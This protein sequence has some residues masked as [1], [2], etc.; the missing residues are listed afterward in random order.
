MP[1]IINKIQNMNA[2]EGAIDDVEVIGGYKV[3]QT[4]AELQAL[5]ELHVNEGKKILTN[6]CA[7][8]VAATGILYRWD[9]GN[10]QFVAK[11]EED[12]ALVATT[13]NFY[14]LQNIPTLTV[15][16]D[17]VL[18]ATGTVS[19]EGVSEGE[20]D[21]I[22]QQLREEIAAGG[23]SGGTVNLNIEDG[24]GTGAVQQVAD[25]VEGGF[26]F[27]G[28]N[29]NAASFDSSLNGTVPYGAT[30][31]YAAAF[32]GVNSASGSRAFAVNN[33]TIAKGDE[34]FAQGYCSVALGGSSFAGGVKTTAVGEGAVSLG[35][36]TKAVGDYTTAEGSETIAS[37]KH[38]HAEGYQTN[39]TV[40]AEGSHAEGVR[41]TTS[42]VAAHAEGDGTFATGAFSHAEG[43]RARATG[44][45]AHAEG[46]DTLA[47]GNHSHAEGTNCVAEGDHSHAGG[48]NSTAKGW[49]SFA[50][51][52][53]VIATAEGQ[54]VV[55]KFNWSDTNSLFEVG[56]GKDADNRANAFW[57]TNDGRA[58][59]RTAPVDD[60]DV[61]TKGFMT[62]AHEKLATKEQLANA[63]L[64]AV[65]FYLHTIRFIF[66]I[67]KTEH[68]DYST[69]YLDMD[70]ILPCENPT[71]NDTVTN[72]VW[73]LNFVN[74]TLY[75][76]KA[77][78]GIG[79]V[80][81]G[82]KVARIRAVRLVPNLTTHWMLYVDEPDKN[83][84]TFPSL[85]VKAATGSPVSFKRIRTIP[86][87][88]DSYYAN[89]EQTID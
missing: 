7:V 85:T 55:G 36:Q 40:D 84:N 14:D 34:S 48:V 3:V 38:S 67:D 70:V 37:G 10:K 6:G 69:P 71:V 19:I 83:Y 30:G 42:G 61:V 2:D 24:T 81:M 89:E 56:M 76:D 59:L 17:G 41:T 27:A 73:V 47:S 22:V 18:D 35:C 72:G 13:G 23:G 65:P 29:A 66:P 54:A 60:N 58:K 75:L 28:K 5:Q 80:N 44:E 51:G 86:F 26:S 9:D 11:N 15:D 1:K 21:A 57:V 78:W 16:D 31:N 63:A 74:T 25:G 77:V 20:F 53:G 82:T 12:Y 46:V 33:K 88:G 52:N 45:G 87:M 43:A 39:T 49:G 4:P 79:S 64:G 50:H 32:G 8:Y 62:A 68:P